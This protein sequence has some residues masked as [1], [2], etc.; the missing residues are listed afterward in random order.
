M[1]VPKI[2]V[3]IP[4][5]GVESY[6]DRCVR[7]IVNQSYRN[8]EIILVDDGSP[9]NCPAMCDEWAKRDAR[10]K[11]L[12]KING[13]LS[14]ARNAGMSIAT[15]E[16]I[17]FV[18]SDD[19][20]ST[21]M[22][23]FLY[24]NMVK[25]DSDISACGVKMVWDDESQNKILTPKGNYVLN[26]QEAM[27]AIIQESILKQPVWYKLYKTK[28]VRD[29]PFPVGRCN[30]DVFWSY[31]A[32][33]KAYRVSVFETPCYYYFQRKDS[34]MGKAYSLKRL[35]ALDAKLE[36]LEY[37]ETNI[38]E[39][40]ELAKWDLWFSSMYSM[41]RSLKCLSPMEY[42]IARQKIRKITKDIESIHCY[43]GIAIKQKIWFCLSKISFEKTC[44]LRNV[45]KVGL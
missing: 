27:E 4:V 36:R 39:L 6:I 42:K 26:R 37:M 12:H 10:I 16:L 3:I 11:V 25:S 8:L 14:D 17:G 20:V 45:L 2:S 18:D 7:S 41:Q 31:Q 28:L 19:W 13:G 5:Y 34:I 21:E 1:S 24:E 23:Q 9:D 44:K 43:K 22:Y 33:G 40:R 32:I 15:G 35:D 38:P 29:I 30:E